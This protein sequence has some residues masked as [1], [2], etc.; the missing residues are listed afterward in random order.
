MSDTPKEYIFETLAELEQI[1]S[2]KI[3]LFLVDLKHWIELR[4]L[5]RKMNDLV[6]SM[7]GGD[8]RIEPH[9]DAMIW[10]DDGANEI[11]LTINSDTEDTQ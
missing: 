7:V 4:Q 10:V 1:P 9:D 11:S 3:D 2:D 6:Q 5:S 8:A